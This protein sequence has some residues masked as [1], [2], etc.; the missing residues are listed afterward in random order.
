MPNCEKNLDLYFLLLREES[1][2]YIL[3]IKYRAYCSSPFIPI[4]IIEYINDYGEYP[5]IPPLVIMYCTLHDNMF[6]TT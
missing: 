1:R 6:T 2:I 4:I 5:A 3:A